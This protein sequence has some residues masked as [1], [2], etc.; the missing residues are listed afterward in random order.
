MTPFCF[1]HVFLAPSTEALFEAYFDVT[2]QIE[3]DRAVEIVERETLELVDRGDELHRVSRVVPRRQLPA[4]LKPFSSGPL[5]YLESVTWRRRADEIAIEIQPSLMQ[6][7]ARIDATYRLDVAGPGSIRR[8]YA[9]Q[10]SVDVALISSRVERG[11][12]AEFGRSMPLA[13]A[14]TQAWLNRRSLPSVTARA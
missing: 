5:H 2:H 7:R 12:V 3:Q 13:A 14:C 9:G 11:I 4:L 10:V 6:G 8:R 1:E